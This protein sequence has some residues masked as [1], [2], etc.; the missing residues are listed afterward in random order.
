M[1]LTL[2]RD[3]TPAETLLTGTISSQEPAEVVRAALADL[4]G[5]TGAVA[6]VL[7]L[8][9]QYGPSVPVFV[10][11]AEGAPL[12]VQAA[13]AV[14]P[15]TL[16][17]D[18]GLACM[19]FPLAVELDVVA[20]L[21]LV[22]PASMDTEKTREHVS[23]AS[24][25]LT[26][27]S[28]SAGSRQSAGVESNRFR[29]DALTGRPN[30][31]F[32]LKHL[33]EKMNG[34]LDFAVL[35]CDLDGF[36]TVNDTLGHG[37]G[38]NLL[39][40]V[41]QRLAAALPHGDILARL[42]GDEF[43]AIVY[44][45]TQNDAQQ[46]ATTLIGTLAD[47]FTVGVHNVSVG[48]SIGIALPTLTMNA[49]DLICAAD[50]AMYEAKKLRSCA[51]AL[52]TPALHAQTEKRRMLE[53][54]LRHAIERDELSVVF[55]PVTRLQTGEL[56]GVEA[57]LRWTHPTLGKVGPSTFIPLAEKSRLIDDLGRFVLASALSEF[58]RMK[59][60]HGLAA[61]KYVAVNVS[62]YQLDATDFVAHLAEVVARFGIDPSELHLEL[63]ES[64]SLL[65]ATT[66]RMILNDITS[67]GIRI[68]IDDFGVGYSSIAYLT[69]L[70]SLSAIKLDSSMIWQMAEDDRARTTVRAMIG[71]AH[72]LGLLLLAEGIETTWQ[73]DWLMENGC[74]LGQGFALGVPM[75]PQVLSALLATTS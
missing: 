44:A 17:A 20:N 51:S 22:Y 67:L 74:D 13:L 10:F 2:D 72:E 4:L 62:P 14:D 38:D 75:P 25:L 42:G 3:V 57:L 35:F 36:K 12:A 11:T 54:D 8:T 19:V 24:G 45:P 66:A 43:L 15:F 68:D 29:V 39:R 30:R 48:V 6:A 37:V 23:Q 64:A 59:D 46:L 28:L 40:Q 50:I 63:T 60:V 65:D 16:P 33:T 69:Q 1:R 9:D 32:A 49:D 58:V 34:P 41:A 56:A 53:H 21:T 52:Y 18:E 27:A 26:L 55:Q 31:A 70:P 47:D 71:L 7:S 73:R 5:L 61:P